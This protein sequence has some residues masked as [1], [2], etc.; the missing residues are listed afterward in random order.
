LQVSEY[1]KQLFEI[2]T[3]KSFRTFQFI[4]IYLT[5]ILFIGNDQVIIKT[6][7]YTGEKIIR[8]TQISNDVQ[9]LL[10]SVDFNLI[11]SLTSK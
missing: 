8:Q 10:F 7:L 11:Q 6:S 2:K 9:F 1:I 4:L 5:L 3:S